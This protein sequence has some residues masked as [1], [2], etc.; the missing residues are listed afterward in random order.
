MLILGK[1]RD[2][3]GTQF[4][5]LTRSILSKL[6]FTNIILNKIGSGGEEIDVSAEMEITKIGKPQR[7]DVICECKAHKN[8]VDMND[9][10][11]FL[12]KVFTAEKQKRQ[13]V[14]GYFVALNG[15]N[16]PVAGHY[17]GLVDHGISTVV[18]IN[19]EDL[20][21][22]VYDIYKFCDL[23]IIKQTVQELTKR[24]VRSFEEIAYYNNQ[25]FRIVIFEANSYTILQGD[26]QPI[27]RGVFN[28]VLK[29][30]VELALPAM[31]FIDLQEEAEAINKVI[32][33]QKFVISQL[34][35]SGGTI[36]RNSV[37]LVGEFT[38]QEINDAIEKLCEQT[39]LKQS[40]DH[41]I[42]F[43]ENENNP[44]LYAVLAEIYRFLLK[45]EITDLVLKALASEY[46]KNNINETFLSEI[47]Q[48]QGGLPLSPEEVH[49]VIL[50]L[51]WSPEAL[52]W[53]L[54]PHE[55]LVNSPIQMS[56]VNSDTQESANLLFR[57]YFFSVL[58]ILFQN[59]F[60]NPEFYT[61][62]YTDYGLR[63]IE[64]LEKL[65]VKSSTGIEFEG[66]LKLRQAIIVMGKKYIN[67]D[68][69]L[70]VMIIPLDSSPEPWESTTESVE[71]NFES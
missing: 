47:Q 41:E 11:K 70:P 69:D 62:F 1:S 42:L 19:G 49:Q 60:R 56:L 44:K 68:V 38:I 28:S 17:Q 3:K 36:A 55:M 71:E 39:W 2:D 14:Y 33:T 7:L 43:I 8:P 10:L 18:L 26:G 6:N 54:D 58:Y 61:H 9:W 4:E 37:P 57:N 30:P 20:L 27:T 21:Q 45:G 52:A 64:T 46:H 12:G 34:F 51:K 25:V 22:H 5:N 63:E 67:S 15:V 59:D 23:E 48:I 29:E 50:L 31:N 32:R 24:Q 35:L 65:I 13:T 66:E 40:D 16:G 53:S